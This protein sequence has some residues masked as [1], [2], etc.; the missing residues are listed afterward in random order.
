M[1]GDGYAALEQRNK[2]C[3]GDTVEIMKPDGENLPVTVEKM[4]DEKGQDIGSCPHPQQK[5]KVLFSE[6]PEA[7]DIIR[8]QNID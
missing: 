5:I 6:A 4:L 8:I 2:F 3:V 7:M 1:D